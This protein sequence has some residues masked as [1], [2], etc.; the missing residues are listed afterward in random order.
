MFRNMLVV[1][2]DE[3]LAPRP[4][5]KLEDDPLST[6]R[7]FCD[8]YAGPVL[9]VRLVTGYSTAA[10]RLW[11]TVPRVQIWLPVTSSAQSAR[12]NGD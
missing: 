9:P 5:S 1:D 8:I 6:V 10:G 11:A 7:D 12:G 2:G 4:T 3:L